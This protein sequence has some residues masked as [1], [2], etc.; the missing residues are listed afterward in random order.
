MS[1]VNPSDDQIRICFKERESAVPGFQRHPLQLTPATQVVHRALKC[2]LLLQ[3]RYGK[4]LTALQQWLMSYIFHQTPF[5]IVDL[6]IC[7]MEDIIFD[8]IRMRR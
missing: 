2:T 6:L 7:K 1:G 5:D 8:G 3:S 4:A